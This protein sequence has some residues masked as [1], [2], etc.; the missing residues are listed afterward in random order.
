VVNADGSV[1]GNAV[2]VVEPP[3]VAQAARGRNFGSLESFRALANPWTNFATYL[4]IAV[5]CFGLLTLVSYVAPDDSFSLLYSVLHV[6]AVVAC[7]GGVFCVVAAL[8]A[9]ATGNRSY[10]V[11]T[12]GF[13]YRQNSNVRALAWPEVTSL[14]SV[15]GTRGS[16][17]GK[18]LYYKLLSQGGKPIA[19]P[20]KIVNGKDDF[21][22]HLIAALGRNDRPV[23]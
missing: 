19:I 20:I 13:V 18:L 11:Y 1:P 10:F 8:R 4:V 12:N 23:N 7:L 9:L 5:V 21:L 14:Q 16:T 2:A 22:D 6:V 15:L 3:D 17:A